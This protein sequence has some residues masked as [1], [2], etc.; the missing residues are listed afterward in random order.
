MNNFLFIDFGASKVKT[1]QYN[2]QENTF[3]NQ[4]QIDSPFL[5][6]ETIHK[7]KLLTFLSNLVKDHKGIDGIV[8]CSIL[9]GG[10]EG[11][12]Y[13]SWKVDKRLTKKT[14]LLSEL[15]KDYDSYHI[16]KDHGG[17][18]DVL[19]L[20][21]KLGN[22]NFY[23]SL[24]DTECV[25]RSFPLSAES[26]IVNL[27]TGSQ[28]IKPN[29]IVKYIPSGRA[30]NTYRDFFLEL[31]IDIF[32][33]F[34]D[35]EMEDLLE[36]HMHFDLNIFNQS[37][38]YKSPGGMI[39]GIHERNFT[40]NNFINSLFSSYLNQ[41]IPYISDSDKIY[42]TGGISRR[43]PII[44][45]YFETKTGKEVFLR[46][47]HIEDTFLGVKNKLIKDYEYINNRR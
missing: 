22:S 28:V 12:I 25:K 1:I 7:K 4:K 27:G 46:S 30:L 43:Y 26:C 31:G 32:D 38:K 3:C 9:G 35:I 36:S 5:E 20:L 17:E 45:K 47:E 41:Y 44:K 10:Y 8:A 37:L 33:V 11:D 29:S 16:H 19:T 34:K 42:L 18:E 24:G 13:Y 39:T 14:C 23:S 2:I 15:F 40:F 6:N 21:G